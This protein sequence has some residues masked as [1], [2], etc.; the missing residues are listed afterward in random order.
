MGLAVL[1]YA[2]WPESPRY[3]PVSHAQYL[4]WW[5]KLKKLWILAPGSR[6]GLGILF[7]VYSALLESAISWWVR[8]AH[9]SPNS[10]KEAQLF[11]F[12]EKACPMSPHQQQTSTDPRASGLFVQSNAL[13]AGADEPGEGIPA[14][15]GLVEGAGGEECGKETQ[16]TVPRSSLA[17]EEFNFFLKSILA[18][19]N[20]LF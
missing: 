3:P 7:S 15:Q 18:T 19:S 6:V 2:G 12:S 17:L 5:S 11:Q 10:P 16:Q 13:P 20:L 9:P 1:V 14:M 8:D 4:F